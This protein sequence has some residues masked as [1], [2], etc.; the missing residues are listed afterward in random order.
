MNTLLEQMQSLYN[1]EKYFIEYND[2]DIDYN[3]GYWGEIVDPDGKKRDLLAEKDQ[4]IEDV[5]YVWE[6][7]NSLTVGKILDVGCGLGSL[8]SAVSDKWDKYGIEIS[9]TAEKF[10]SKHC[11]VHVGN[12]FD[13]PYNVDQFDCI[14]MYHVIE[15]VQDPIANIKLIKKLIKNKGTLIIGTPDFDSGCARRFGEN[16]RLLGPGHIRLF[17]NDSMHRFLR[18]HGFKINKVEYPFFNSRLFN[19]GNLIRLLDISKVSPPF[20]GNYM[21][22]FCTNQK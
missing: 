5:R 1:T 14:T 19:K 6:Y 3:E 18:D 9:K 4:Q 22:F 15:H 20:Y 16:Y 10:A 21:T 7:V 2:A 8:L 13:C 11:K 17:S 12:L